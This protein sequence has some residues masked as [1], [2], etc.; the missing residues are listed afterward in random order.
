MLLPLHSLAYLM[1]IRALYLSAFWHYFMA[2][3][4]F[5]SRRVQQSEWMSHLCRD[6]S[7]YAIGS[8]LDVSRLNLSFDRSRMHASVCVE[9]VSK[10]FLCLITWKKM[11][12]YNKNKQNSK[13]T[14]TVLSTTALFCVFSSRT[15]FL[16]R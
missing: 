6:C 13:K 12:W 4:L 9:H 7:Y 5:Q 16:V 10:R 3:L 1:N 14:G 15:N 2:Q 11:L 8:F